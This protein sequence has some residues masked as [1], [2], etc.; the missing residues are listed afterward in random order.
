[1]KCFYVWFANYYSYLVCL[2]PGVVLFCCF[3]W[4]FELVVVVGWLL[5]CF[6]YGGLL[7]GL[8]TCGNLA[9]LLSVFGFKLFAFW[10]GWLDDELFVRLLRVLIG[11]V[12]YI[13][14]LWYG[15]VA[16]GVHL[17]CFCCA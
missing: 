4:G 13:W 2:L 7:I 3:F 15:F 6:G 10:C 17:N 16:V 8:I 5:F 14:V 11:S 1:M 12:A 9:C